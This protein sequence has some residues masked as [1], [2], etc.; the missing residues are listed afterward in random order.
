MRFSNK[1]VR[2]QTYTVFQCLTHKTLA[3]LMATIVAVV[4]LCAFCMSGCSVQTVAT[5]RTDE[6]AGIVAGSESE[7]GDTIEF[8]DS[9]G[10]KMRIPKNIER[11]VPSGHVATMVLLSF[12]AKKLVSVGSQVDDDTLTY[13]ADADYIKNLPATGA[14]FGGKGDL[15]KEEIGKLNPQILIDVGESKDGIADDLDE[16]QN[17]LGIPCIFISA[18]LSSYANTY[19]LLGQI[20]GESE[21]AAELGTFATNAYSSAQNAKTNAAQVPKI[22]NIVGTDG[23]NAIAKGTYQSAVIDVVA[24]N[25]VSVENPVNKGSG[26]T[27]DLE[28]LNNFNPS[29]LFFQDEDVMNEALNSDAWKSMAALIENRVY[30]VPSEPYCWLNNP[31]SVN[32]ILGLTWM[33]HLLYPE[34]FFDSLE[35]AVNSY[36]QTFYGKSLSEDELSKLLTCAR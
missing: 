24:E 32:Q 20:F 28:Q 19:D 9:V 21:R 16:L 35:S 30:F 7:N 22:A 13:Y 15:N 26:N 5:T 18:T 11:V 27:I 25:A 14:A 1:T 36:F 23:V 12:D 3:V 10:R 6:P 4:F 33:S 29:I 34:Q 17:Q 2:C 8:V 31:P